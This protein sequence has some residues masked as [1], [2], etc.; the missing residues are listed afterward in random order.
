MKNK[1]FK[2]FIA[3]VALAMALLSL[4]SLTAFASGEDYEWEMSFDGKTLYYDKAY[5]YY[6]ASMPLYPIANDVYVYSQDIFYCNIE[7]NRLSD[8]GIV[9]VEESEIEFYATESGK[10]RLDAF[11]GGDIGGYL[12]SKEDDVYFNGELDENILERLDGLTETN[13]LSLF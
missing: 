13:Q 4:F 1:A 8:D 9:W 11:M 2:K 10:A 7:R 5:E 3:T 6:K 12:L